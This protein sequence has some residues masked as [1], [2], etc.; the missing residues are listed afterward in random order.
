M[1]PKDDVTAMKEAICRVAEEKPF[2]AEA[3]RAYASRFDADQK[4]G[5]YIKLYGL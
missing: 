4:F 3:C 1:V 5:D 2:S